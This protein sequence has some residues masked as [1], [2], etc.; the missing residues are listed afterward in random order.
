MP[1]K[2]SEERREMTRSGY[3]ERQL[4]RRISR[5][6][7]LA[8]LAGSGAALAA[9]SLTGCGGGEDKDGKEEGATSGDKEAPRTG[10]ILNQTLHTDPAPNLDPHQTTTFTTV[11]PVA[12][13]LNQL[14]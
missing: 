1:A 8:A 4:V 11:W 7:A 9:L 6:R 10:G 13:T 3:W 12:P 5:R 2:P 14:V